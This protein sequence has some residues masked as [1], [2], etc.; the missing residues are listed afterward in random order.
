MRFE[1]PLVDAPATPR[2][3]IAIIGLDRI[4]LESPISAEMPSVLPEGAFVE[5]IEGRLSIGVVGDDPSPV[6]AAV[7]GGPLG[8][9]LEFARRI[10][11]IVPAVTTAAF[12]L[13]LVVP[14]E[15][16]GELR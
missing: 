7:A 15:A 2:R 4:L 3:E 1:L 5:I 12:P 16:V 6:V 9:P 11:S 13:V 10:A 14:L 8:E